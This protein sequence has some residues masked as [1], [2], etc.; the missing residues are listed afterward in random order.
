MISCVLQ[1]HMIKKPSYEDEE[2]SIGDR[3]IRKNATTNALEELGATLSFIDIWLK[4][5]DGNYEV[6]Y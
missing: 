4:L 6:I 3:T 1:L 5:F 2:I